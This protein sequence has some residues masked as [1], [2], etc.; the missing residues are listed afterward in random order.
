ME[1]AS[2]PEVFYPISWHDAA[3]LYGPA[4]QVEQRLTENTRGIHLYN[5][6]LRE[7]AKSRPPEGSFMAKQFARFGL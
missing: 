7:L 5:S 3:S 1:H 2:D 6:Q 4:E